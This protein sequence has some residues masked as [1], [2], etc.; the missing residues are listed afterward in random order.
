MV[1][2]KIE[3]LNCRSFSPGEKVR[4]RGKAALTLNCAGRNLNDHF[5][6]TPALSL[7]EREKRSQRFGIDT[8]EFSNITAALCRDAATK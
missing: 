3:R 1:F 2:A 6:L 7:R 8:A 5:P 4:M